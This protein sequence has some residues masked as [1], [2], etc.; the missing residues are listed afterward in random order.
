MNFKA[1]LFSISLCLIISCGKNEQKSDIKES[2]LD[3][4]AIL[5]YPFGTLLTIEVTIIDG[6]DTYLKENQDKFLFKLMS[7]NNKKINDTIIMTFE[8]D[9]KKFFKTRFELYEKYENNEDM[10]R[11]K[12]KEYI[13][14]TYRIVAYE[15]GK[16]TGIPE[17]YFEYQPLKAD[18]GFHFENYLVIVADLTN[19]Q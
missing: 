13:N 3:V 17:G 8:D 7:I 15:T 1:F 12:E 14:K 19:S 4:K 18:T 5:G 11:K 9:T 10:V 16:F 6:Y 2:N